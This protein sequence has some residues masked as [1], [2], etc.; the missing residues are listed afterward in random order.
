MKC[1]ICGKKAKWRYSPDLDIN[2]IGA[3][4]K[5]K[6]D[7]HTYYFALI[8]D[9]KLFWDLIKSHKDYHGK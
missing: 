2:G 9:E 8:T 5:H 4:N 1:I 7:V 3:C 6:K